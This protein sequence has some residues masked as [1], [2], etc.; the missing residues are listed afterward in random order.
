MSARWYLWEGGFLAVG[1]GDG[2]VPPH[3]HHA[4]QIVIAING[5]VAI[6]GDSD[7]WRDCP[8]FIVRPD[9]EH[10]F[11][12][13]GADAAMLFVDPESREGV[14]LRT[15]LS[16]DIT[17]VPEARVSACAPVLR[18][19]LDRPLESIDVSEVIRRCVSALCMG[20]PPSRRFD[21]RVTKVLTAIRESDD[22]RMSLAGC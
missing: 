12:G 13:K 17:L 20:T 14:W 9:V 10:S 16:T 5:L 11:N 1:K 7:G 22:L 6:H 8:G 2:V 18:T 3:S 21:E 4:I 15:T 19:F